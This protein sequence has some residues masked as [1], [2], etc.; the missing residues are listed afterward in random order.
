M[1]DLA[2][3]TAR[4]TCLCHEFVAGHLIDITTANKYID[5]V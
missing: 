2:A 1:V 3:N 4:L 5:L